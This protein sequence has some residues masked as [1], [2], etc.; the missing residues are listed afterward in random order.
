MINST[1]KTSGMGLHSLDIC[2]PVLTTATITALPC[3]K[4]A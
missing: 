4:A 1:C 3:M 2:L